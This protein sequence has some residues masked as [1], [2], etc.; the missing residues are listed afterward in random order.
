MAGVA[1]LLSMV[2]LGVWWARREAADRA[3]DAALSD[4]AATPLPAPGDPVDPRLA[5]LGAEVFQARCSACHV[6]KGEPKLGP[7]LAGVTLRRELGWIRSMILRPDS[8][9]V[10]DPVASALKAAYGVQM[11]VIGSM[12][13]VHVRAVIEFL[14]RADTGTGG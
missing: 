8:M 14:R 13:E 4:Y 7:N 6:V 9:T 5:D 1:V 10:A 11:M 2:V 3:L 12:T